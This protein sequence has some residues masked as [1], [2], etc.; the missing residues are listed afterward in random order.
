MRS[1][2]RSGR[3][4]P[5][6]SVPS[7]AST[8]SIMSSWGHGG[9]SGDTVGTR[10]GQRVVSVSDTCD[11]WKQRRGVSVSVSVSIRVYCIYGIYV[12]HRCN[13]RWEEQFYG[14]PLSLTL[15]CMHPISPLV[16]WHLP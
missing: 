1:V 7:S 2:E 15:G 6:L 12:A 3:W 4:T 10:W 5:P 9:D 16:S 13:V 11:R 8:N 14:R